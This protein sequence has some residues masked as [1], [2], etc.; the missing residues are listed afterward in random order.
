VK[1]VSDE[2]FMVE[3]PQ[4]VKAHGDHKLEEMFLL[5]NEDCLW[6]RRWSGALVSTALEGNPESR[7]AMT[8]WVTN[9]LPRAEEALA[10]V[11]AALSGDGRPSLARANARVRG[12]LSS[13]GVA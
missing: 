5:L 2:F 12:W 11:S 6:Q 4:R 3:L 8:S 1:P 7:S 9:W 10:A 13:L